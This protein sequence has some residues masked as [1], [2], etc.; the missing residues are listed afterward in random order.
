[1][2]S[3]PVANHPTCRRRP[4]VVIAAAVI[5]MASCGSDATP[6]AE[7]TP[8]VQAVCTAANEGLISLAGN[9]PGEWMLDS[10]EDFLFD[11][12]TGLPDDE[13]DIGRPDYTIGDEVQAVRRTL[14]LV[15][16]TY[17]AGADSFDPVE[18]EEAL[19]R[20]FPNINA[21]AAQFGVEVCVQSTVLD[22]VIIPQLA[23]ATAFRSGME[24]TG[25][26]DVDVT[27]VC[28]RYRA[29]EAEVLIDNLTDPNSKLLATVRIRELLEGLETDLGLLDAPSDRRADFDAV[30]MAIADAIVG[31]RAVDS[32]QR[33]DQ[34]ALDSAIVEFDRLDRELGARLEVLHPG[35]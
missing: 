27:G 7:L 8:A 20:D 9:D 31:V 10:A 29:N 23:A 11:I 5:V 12:V 24:P 26:F 25:D 17:D 2:S 3:E 18:L 35:C 14:R 1:M 22:D 19:R 28:E 32:A 34:N 33:L 21:G 15:Q 30:M 16:D 6:A 13:T 4:A